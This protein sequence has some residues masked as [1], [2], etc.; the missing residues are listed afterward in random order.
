MTDIY[1]FQLDNL[2]IEEMTDF[3]KTMTISD[4]LEQNKNKFISHQ[5]D[6]FGNEVSRIK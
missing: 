6:S 1:K 4:F 3:Q 2:T 5:T